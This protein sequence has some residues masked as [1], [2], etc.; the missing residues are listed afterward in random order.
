MTERLKHTPGPWT[1][2][3]KMDGS[4]SAQIR[5]E[6]GNIWIGGAMGSHYA[7]DRRDHA[8]F[9]SDMEGE[10]NA[11]LIAAAP[12]LLEAAK[13]AVAYDEAIRGCAN[14][15]DKMS[16]YCTAGGDDLDTLYFRWLTLARAG[17]A[18]VEGGAG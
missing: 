12:D 16:S 7:A 18:K 8:G 9:P 1:T 13:A 3:G 14:D 17:I 11:R 2:R 4:G 15:P 10:A 6:G 5:A